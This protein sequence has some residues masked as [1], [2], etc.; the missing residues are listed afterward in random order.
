VDPGPATT[1]PR[2]REELQRIG[3][4]K[5]ELRHLF[6]THVHLDHAGAAGA[7]V[8][9][10]PELLVHVHA[11]AARFLEDPTRLVASTRRT[12]GEAHDRLWGE[13][14]PVPAERIQSWTPEGRGLPPG[15]VGI[16]TPGHIDHH[17]AW[18]LPGEGV[19]L[20]GDALGVILDPAAPTH[21]PTPPP[22][23]DLPAWGRTLR[24]LSELEVERAGVTHFGW[25]ESVASRAMELLG[26]LQALAARV[27]REL[28]T[29]VPEASRRYHDETVAR[30]AASGDGTRIRRYFSRF[31]ASADWD[32]VRFHLERKGWPGLL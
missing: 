24:R 26:E 11:D 31:R 8:Q 17:L 9:E 25:H 12:F 6:L 22:S 21:P 32:G 4:G 28:E 20:T 2:L 16:P 3:V 7:L 15:V 10:H 23:L 29:G 5:G 14:K 19:V 30:L 27:R 18:L 13:M 1:L